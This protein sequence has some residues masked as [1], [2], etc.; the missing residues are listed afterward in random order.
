MMNFIFQHSRQ[1]LE[2]PGLR[3]VANAIRTGLFIER[4]YSGLSTSHMMIIDDSIRSQLQVLQIAT[5]TSIDFMLNF[6]DN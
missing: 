3:S 5:Q 6:L 4:I 1:E 2:R